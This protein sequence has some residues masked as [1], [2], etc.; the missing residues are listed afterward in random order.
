M[1]IFHVVGCPEKRGVSSEKHGE[2]IKRRRRKLS[3]SAD[4]W[5]GWLECCSHDFAWF[6]VSFSISAPLRNNSSHCAMCTHSCNFISVDP[7]NISRVMYGTAPVPNKQTTLSFR[8]RTQN[9]FTLRQNHTFISWK[10][11]RK[12]SGCEHAKPALVVPLIS[13]LK[14][15]EGEF[16]LNYVVCW[17]KQCKASNDK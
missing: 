17:T 15:Q 2:L 13:N 1:G 11:L 14:N 16:T 8:E 5:V 3:S 7:E 12:R 6:T 9:L 4:S 10:Q